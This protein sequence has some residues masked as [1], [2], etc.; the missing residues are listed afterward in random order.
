MAILST[1]PI[2]NDPNVGARPTQQVIV[3][4]VNTD[5]INSSLVLIEGFYLN[6]IRTLYVQEQV[7]LS[8]NEVETR[9]YF[10]NFDAYEYVI[11]TSGPAEESTEISIWGTS[12]SGELTALHRLVS[13]EQLEE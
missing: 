2:D 8:P 10:A 5:S 11:T 6:G 4:M 9:N 12:A 1:G 3:K 13:E 7:E